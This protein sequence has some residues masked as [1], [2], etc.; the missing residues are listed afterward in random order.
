MNRINKARWTVAGTLRGIT[1]L[2]L[3]IAVA[4]TASAGSQVFAA[5]GPRKKTGTRPPVIAERYEYYEICGGCEQD[6][7]S[8]LKKKCIQWNDGKKYDSMTN[9]K[10]K[11][12][13]GHN[14]GSGTCAVDSFT[15]TVDITFHVPKW[16]RTDNAPHPLV[17]KWDNYLKNLM[18]HERGHRDRTVEA[19]N[20]LTRAVAALPPAGTCDELDREIQ[21]L[22]LAQKNKL[23]QDQKDYDNE[24]NHGAAQ[25]AVFP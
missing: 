18:T 17:A 11:W 9:W 15:V 2:L 23:L 22:G 25:G 6:L 4:G 24:T 1:A 3:F 8:D 21:T 10:L 16:S 20:D 7:K 12:D 19:A 13:Y 5:T 14:E